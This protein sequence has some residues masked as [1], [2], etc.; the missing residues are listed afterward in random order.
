MR[1][2]HGF[3]LIELLIVVAIIAILAAIAVPNF[4]E[5]QVRAK[6]T[7]VINDQRTAATAIEAYA[8]DNGRVPIGQ[9]ECTISSGATGPNTY[10]SGSKRT[11]FLW[12]QLTTPIAYM[13]SPPLDI[14]SEIAGRSSTPGGSRSG[15]EQL[16]RY[17]A[18]TPRYVLGG[19][20]TMGNNW[21]KMRGRGVAWYAY[22]LGPSRSWRP[23]ETIGSSISSAM[24]GLLDNST[25][26]AHPG[27][28]YDATNGTKSF[29]FLTRSNRGVE[30][31]S[32]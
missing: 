4:L 15:Y 22:S 12:S 26:N 27:A 24:A 16:M 6:I 25:R 18:V 28:F 1:K 3:T 13:Q 21:D 2:V 8:V 9:K 29:G 14:F 5:A 11:A 23:N 7:R 32:N 10:D 20:A 31:A 19:Q 30:P 17:E